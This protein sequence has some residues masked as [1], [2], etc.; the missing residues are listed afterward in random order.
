MAE[1]N[2]IPQLEALE[3]EVANDSAEVE[4]ITEKKSEEEAAE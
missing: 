3:E 1:E 4:V 2:K